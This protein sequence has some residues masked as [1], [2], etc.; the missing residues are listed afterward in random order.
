M[1][2]HGQRKNNN[3]VPERT[4]LAVTEVKSQTEQNSSAQLQPIVNWADFLPLFQF[5]NGNR[6]RLYTVLGQTPPRAL[7]VPRYAIG[8][9][10]MVKSVLIASI[11]HELVRD[12]SIEKAILQKE[13]F[14]VALIQFFYWYG[15]E[16]RIEQYLVND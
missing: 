1:I 16:K 12:F 14:E 3:Y 4:N 6:G 7:K 13:I 5:L 11:I 9:G 15:Y 2:F 8:G 10:H